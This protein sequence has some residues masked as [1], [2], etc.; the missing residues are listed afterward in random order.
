MAKCF[1]VTLAGYPQVFSHFMPDNGLANLAACLVR[2]GHEVKIFD[3]NTLSVVDG[4]FP[5]GLK[6]KA[7][8]AFERREPSMISDLY[9]E[10]DDYWRKGFR[11]LGRDLTEAIRREKPDWVGFKLWNGDGY[12]ASKLMAEEIKRFFPSMPIIAGGS[13]ADV[14][15]ET[16]LMDT[17]AFDYLTHKEGEPMIVK[18]SEFIDGKL[19]LEGVPNLIFRRNGSIVKTPVARVENLDEIPTAVY[20]EAVYPGLKGDEKTKMA[21]FEES[22]GCRNNCAFCTHT[23][24]SGALRIKSIETCLSQLAEL[25]EKY[26]YCAYKLGGSF[27]PSRFINDLAKSILESGFSMEW[28]SYGHLSDVQHADFQLWKKAG[29]RAL[30]FGLESGDQ[31]LLDQVHNKGNS[32]ETIKRSLQEVKSAG[33]FTITSIIYPNPGET[34]NSR[35]A[36]LKLLSEIKPDSIPCHFPM[37]LPGALWEK[38]PERFGFQIKNPSTYRQEILNYKAR[39]MYP[40][41]FWPEIPVIVDGKEYPRYAAENAEMVMELEK[42]GFLTLLSDENALAARLAG[43]PARDLRNDTARAFFCGDIM[44]IADIIASVN[45]GVVRLSEKNATGDND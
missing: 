41:E 2:S 28:A 1:L 34:E 25:N 31:L 42:N 3:F 40:P 20:D 22:R 13:H 9:Y 8:S 38:E 30:F 5:E 16:I 33:I 17:D 36:T 11:R 35:N 32:I 26:G 37:L 19:S 21:T 29:C 23:I 12:K 18:F 10:L 6:D 39:L 43:M 27:S 45:Q 4:L 44:K 14:F 24:K 7:R 15:K